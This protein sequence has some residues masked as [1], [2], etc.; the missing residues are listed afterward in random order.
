MC[1]KT[2]MN[3]TGDR[4]NNPINGQTNNPRKRP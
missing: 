4:I 1:N 2:T 3:K